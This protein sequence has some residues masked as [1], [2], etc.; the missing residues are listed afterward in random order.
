MRESMFLATLALAAGPATA[1]TVIRVDC[2][3]GG[4]V[5][6][7]GSWATAFRHPQDA[8]DAASP[9]DEIWVAEGHYAPRRG[10]AV[11]ELAPGVRLFGGFAGDESYR[12]ER[13]PSRH[14][15]VLDGQRAAA[16]VVVAASAS[17]LDG[18]VLLGGRAAG[19]ASA[20]TGGG[21]LAR[22]ISD[23]EVEGCTFLENAARYGG[24]IYLA[25][26]TGCSIRDC[27]FEM[28]AAVEGGAVHLDGASPEIEGCFFLTNSADDGGAIYCIRALPAITRCRFLRNGAAH[29]GGAMLV[30]ADSSPE[31]RRSEFHANSSDYGGAVYAW[32]SSPVFVG[33]GFGSNRA[34]CGGGGVRGG[35]GAVTRLERC[36]FRRNAAAFGGGVSNSGSARMGML[37][38][39]FR[40]NEA[41]HAGADVFGAAPMASG[42]TFTGNRVFGELEAPGDLAA[43]ARTEDLETLAALAASPPAADA[44]GRVF[45]TSAPVSRA[46]E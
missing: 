36:V 37:R 24:G 1:A 30:D 18:F 3:G 7:G 25:R 6:D 9:A 34:S 27:R 35:G 14:R 12:D 28:N 8:V 10:G 21:I 22:G 20:G 19:P 26:T 2:C 40:E 16:H 15:T 32:G 42:C 45:I 43:P 4:A 46:R 38:C 29:G 17:G 11:V 23:F 13:D 41:D 5:R 44:A 39:S 31:T 33:C